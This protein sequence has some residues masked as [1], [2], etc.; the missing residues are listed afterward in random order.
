MSG[1]A[2]GWVYER[3]PYTGAAF[4][5]HLAIADVV[6]DMHGNEFWAANATLCAKARVG[7]QRC[8]EVLGQM[9]ADGLLEVIERPRRGEHAP[10]R[11]RFLMPEG[12]PVVFDGTGRVAVDDTSSTPKVS[13]ETT[14]GVAVDDMK[15]SPEAT[16]SLRGNEKE[17]NGADSPA[18]PSSRSSTARARNGADN[19]GLTPDVPQ[20]SAAATSSENLTPTERARLMNAET[21]RA[22][23]QGTPPEEPDAARL[24]ADRVAAA[25]RC[26]TQ[27]RV[28]V[29]I[30][31][32]FLA[33]GADPETLER[34][35]SGMWTIS[36]GTL[37]VAMSREEE[38]AER[39]KPVLRERPGPPPPPVHVAR[40]RAEISAEE[41]EAIRRVHAESRERRAEILAELA[42]QREGVL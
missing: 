42:A 17:P 34:I 30:L 20:V 6:N 31:G 26:V 2:T 33:R 38:R 5:V 35:A 15:V 21:R 11:Y 40:P 39:A 25:G 22:R 29:P 8:N 7:R 12:A 24:M 18:S 23:A 13:P 3:S 28:M 27:V 1:R 32:A 41:R 9:V 19:A 16:Q 14:P 36:E 4:S 37:G 10:V